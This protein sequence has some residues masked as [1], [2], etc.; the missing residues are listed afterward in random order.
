MNIQVRYRNGQAEVYFNG[1]WRP[2][3]GEWLRARQADGH[4]IVEEGTP[5]A[6][7]PQPA[8]QAAFSRNLPP[9]ATLTPEGAMVRASGAAPSTVQA[10]VPPETLQSAFG[11]NLPAGATLTPEGAMVRTPSV[12]AT[13]TPVQP[14]TDPANPSA[15]Y[16][17]QTGTFNVDPAARWNTATSAPTATPS[18]PIAPPRFDPTE[19]MTPEQLAAERARL[20]QPGEA[21]VD[22]WYQAL[23]GVRQY[24]EGGITPNAVVGEGMETQTAQFDKPQRAEVVLIP[25]GKPGTY[26]ARYAEGP[27]A[28]ALKPRSIIIPLPDTLEGPVKNELLPLDATPLKDS[29]NGELIDTAGQRY[30][31]GGVVTAPQPLIPPYPD[32]WAGLERLPWGNVTDYARGSAAAVNRRN[33][34]LIAG[35]YLGGA[36]GELANFERMA[37]GR[38]QVP[39]WR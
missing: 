26:E 18:A 36:Q 9:G 35:G 28:A 29:G 1:T 23:G 12:T 13:S 27:V 15:V 7:Q 25:T 38:L 39:V 14:P 24:A 21:N 8:L 11:R 17:P 5:S 6:T 30:A 10:Q 34:E 20:G 19:G 33:Q 31:L 3:T 16:N 37:A 22:R 2:T 4:T 32:P